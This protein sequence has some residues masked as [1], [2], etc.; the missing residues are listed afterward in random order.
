MREYVPEAGF[1]AEKLK[2][3]LKVI[4]SSLWWNSK[5]TTLS[6][7]IEIFSCAKNLVGNL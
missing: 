3:K 5:L 7:D 2:T 6:D 4:S 1:L